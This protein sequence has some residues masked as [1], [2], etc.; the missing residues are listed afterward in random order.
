MCDMLTIYNVLS[1]VL[2]NVRA[3]SV[4]ASFEITGKTCIASIQYKENN[5]SLVIPFGM[6]GEKIRMYSLGHSHI[7]VAIK[8]QTIDH[9]F[10]FQMVASTYAVP[11]NNSGALSQSDN[12]RP[13]SCTVDDTDKSVGLYHTIDCVIGRHESGH[14]CIYL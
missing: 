12:T 5:C 13:H 6:E 3:F 7:V 1:D 14:D 9:W 10:L 8:L 2:A 4:C 11:V